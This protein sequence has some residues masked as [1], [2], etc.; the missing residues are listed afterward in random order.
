MGNSGTNW[1]TGGNWNPAAVPVSG[2]VL[3]F[4]P[5][6]TS[7]TLTY[8]NLTAANPS[9]TLLF[10][11]TSPAYTIS[12][13]TF[14]I[15]GTLSNQSSNT[16]TINDTVNWGLASSAATPAVAGTGAIIFNGLVM[17]TVSSPTYIINNSLVA[18]N[19]GYEDNTTGGRTMI[20]SGTGNV[21][22]E[23]VT[24]QATNAGAFQLT[25]EGSGTMILNGSNSGAM[26]GISGQNIGIQIATGGTFVTGVAPYLGNSTLQ[27]QGN[28]TIGNGSGQG[29]LTIKGGNGVVTSGSTQGTLSLEDGTINTLTINSSAAAGS[30]VFTMAGGAGSPSI[31]NMDVGNAGADEIV[32][33]N[34][35]NMKASIGAGGVLVNLNGIGNL[36]AG[37]YKLISGSAGL[38]TI[39]LNSTT[40]N[41]SGFDSVSLT[42]TTGTLSVTLGGLVAAPTNAYWKGDDGADGSGTW[43]TFTGGTN[44]VTNWTSAI[45]GGTNTQQAPGSATN[46]YFIADTGSNMTNTYLGASTTINT[47]NFTGTDATVT[48]GSAVSISGSASGSGTNATLTINSGLTSGLGAGV[49]TISAPVALGGNQTWTLNGSV[50]SVTGTLSGAH[51]LTVAGTGGELI[52]GGANTFSGTL[53]IGNNAMVE[54]NSAGALG[55]NNAVAFSAASSGTLVLNGFGA[56][57]GNLSSGG[58]GGTPV[59][60]NNNVGSAATLTGSQTT[61]GTFAGVIQDGGGLPLSFTKTGAATLTLTGVNTYTGST[62]VNGGALYINGSLG[63]G[64]N[65]AVNS[66]GTLGGSAGTVSG[67]V[68]VN[69]GGTINPGTS[70][71]PT[72]LNLGNGLTL[73]SGGIAAFD[74]VD[75]GANDLLN[76]TGNVTFN[77]GAIIEVTGGMS[78]GHVYTLLT[79]SG[80]APSLSGVTQ[81]DL[82]G[83]SLAVNDPT[84]TLSVSGNSIILTVA[85]ASTAIPG[86]TITSPAAG[87][88]VMQNTANVTVNGNV[89]NTGVV[90]LNG[91]LSSSGGNFTVGN[92]G[93]TSGTFQT[94]TG[95]STAYTGT[96]ASV[97]NTLGLNTFNMTVTDGNALP[98]SATTTGTL[99]VLGN[100][101]VTASTGTFGPIHVGASGSASI[102]LSST[103]ADNLYTRVTVADGG[104]DSGTNGISVTGGA[105]STV[106][107]GTTSDIRS[108]TGSFGSIGVQSGTV[109]LTT[110]SETGLAG[111]SPIN[112]GAGYTAQIFSGKASWASTTGGSWATNG[113]WGDTQ[114]GDLNGAGAPGLAGTASIGDT[115]TFNDVSGQS[116]VST[117]SLNGNSPTLA[118]ITF[119]STNGYTI[120]PGSGGNITLQGASTPVLVST[121]TDTISAVM[122]GTGAGLNKS[123]PGTLILGAAN[124]YTGSTIIANGVVQT[125]TANALPAT[126]SLALGDNGNDSGQLVLGASQTFAGGLSTV[127]TGTS[128]AVVGG[129]T[130]NSL[131]TLNL[132]SVPGAVYTFAGNLGGGIANQNNLALTVS[133]SGVQVIS[134]SITYT[135]ATILSNGA[136]LQTSNMLPGSSSI[137]LNSGATGAAN[138]GVW[139][140]FLTGPTAYNFTLGTTSAGNVSSWTGGGFAAYGGVLTLTANSGGTLVWGSGGFAGT[141]GQSITFGSTTSNNQ[142]VLTNNIN[143]NTTDAFQGNITVNG[144]TAGS[145]TLLSGSILPGTGPSGL[146]KSGAGILYLSGANTYTGATQVANGL[147]IAQNNSLADGATPGAFGLDTS[148]ILIGDLA[149]NNGQSV[150]TGANL[151]VMINGAYTVARP[152]TIG[153]TGN[154]ANSITIGGTSNNTATFSGL[155]TAS[156]SFLVAQAATT[157]ANVLNITNGITGG[158]AGTDTVTFVNIGKVNVSGTISKGAATTLNIVQ[159]GPG[160][161]TLSGSNNYNGITLINQGDLNVTNSVGSATG[162]NT[163]TITPNA[164]NSAVLSGNGIISGA[165]IASATS[166]SVGT[167]HIGPGVNTSGNF[168][169]TGTLTLNGGLTLSNGTD[170]DFD[171]GSSSDLIA[172]TG[173][174]TLGSGITLNIA[175]SSGFS[176]GTPYT[177]IT[178]TGA[179][180]GAT[181]GWSVAGGPPATTD[182]FTSGGGV[183]TVTITPTT[184]AANAYWGGAYGGGG[185]GTWYTFTG[186][187]NYNT[188]WLT[189]QNGGTDPHQVPYPTT[190]VYFI[191]DTG[192]NTNTVLGANFTIN[193]LNF[194]GTDATVT[195]GPAVNILGSVTGSG[196][197]N[198]LTINAT[199]ANGNTPGSGITTGAGAGADTVTANIALGGNQTWTINNAPSTPFTVSGTVSGSQALTVTGTGEL[200]LGGNNTFTNGLTI[201][202][203]SI[204][205]LNS[206][207]ALNAAS[208]DSVTF[209]AGSSG[210]LNLSGNS[211]TVGSLATISGTAAVIQNASAN[212]VVLTGSQTASGT[213]AGVIQDGAGGGSLSFTMNGPAALTLT[214]SNAYTGSTTVNGGELLVN[215]SLGP[216]NVKVNSGGSL[217]GSGGTIN[218]AVTVHSG[219]SITA[220]VGTANSPATL[221]LA[222]GLT[223]SSGG[224]A[225]FNFFNNGSAHDE[226]AVTGNLTLASGA[227]LQVPSGVYISGTYALITYTG[228]NSN[229]TLAGV[230]EESLTGGGLGGN[231]SFQVNGNAIDLVIAPTPLAI[232]GITITSP[233]SGIRVMAGTSV[234]VTG[235]VANSGTQNALSGTLS[236]GGGSLTV[237]N[238]SPGVASVAAGG[239]A[240]YSGTIA[241]GSILGNQTFGVTV[242][243]GSATPTSQTASGTLDVVASRVVISNTAPAFGI[244]HEGAV[245]SGTITLSSTGADIQYTRV[246]VADS[247]APDANGISVTGGNPSET[248]NGTFSDSRVVSGTFTSNGNLNGTLTL[249]TGSEG[250]AGELPINVSV[251]Y[252][253]QVFSGHA[254][255]NGSGSSSWATNTSWG[256]SLNNTGVAGAPGLSG[257]LSLGDTATFGDYAGEIVGGTTTVNLS[258]VSP[259][260][261]GLTFSST[262]TSYAIATGTGAGVINLQNGAAINVSSGTANIAANLSGTG[263][264][265]VAPAA[266][267]D[268]IWSGSD[269]AFTGSANIASGT[270]T[271]VNPTWLGQ[272]AGTNVYNINSGAVLQ[273][274]INSGS[275]ITDPVV[276][277]G[278][279]EGS[280]TLQ[281]TGTGGFYISQGKLALQ[282]SAGAVIEVRNGAT[283]GSGGNGGGGLVTNNNQGTLQLDSGGSINVWNNGQFIVDA[284]T[285]SG[286]VNRIGFGNAGGGGITIGAANGSGIFNGIVTNSLGTLDV[287]KAG[288]GTELFTGANTYSGSTAV[289]GG[290]LR[291]TNSSGLGFTGLTFAAP[292][293]GGQ[294]TT[295]VSGSGA[296]DI[297]NGITLNN[298]ITLNN[299]S[300]IN[301]GTGTSVL[302]SGIAGVTFATDPNVAGPVVVTFGAGGA[303]ASGSYVSSAN[304]TQVYNAGG[305]SATANDYVQM[306]AA[307]SGYTPSAAPT[308]TIT[309]GG[310]ATGADA[311]VVSQLILSGT[312]NFIGGN[313]N[314]AINAQ[315]SGTGG[316]STTGAG[317]VTLTGSEIY[318]GTTIVAS[319]T[320]VDNGYIT[321]P[322]NVGVATLA[323]TGTVAGAVA[324]TASSAA[325]I[326]PGVNTNGNL[327]G[328]GTLTLSGGLTLGNGTNLDFDLGSSSDLIAV[329]GQL[330]LGSGIVLNINK[331]SG[332]SAGS[333]YNLITYSGALTGTTNGWTMAGG[334]TATTGSFT[335]AN[336]TISVSFVPINLPANAY[337]GGAQGSGGNGTWNT[338][339]SGTT[340]NWLTA[341]SSGSDTNQVPYSTTNVFFIANTGS[342]VNTYLGSNFTINSLNFTGTNGVVATGSVVSISGSIP[343]GGVNSSLTI[344]AT[345]INGNSAG[346]GLT[347]GPGAGAETINVNVVLGGNQT[348]TLGASP[349]APLTIGGTISGAHALTVG[350]GGQ[351]VLAGNN[352]F[353]GGLTINGSAS[354]V[355]NNAGALNS[356]TP[357]SVTFGPSSSGT[358]TLAG[359][360][361]AIGSLSSSASAV[362][363][364]IQ[365]ASGTPVLLT[366][367][368]GV[369]G[370]F[371]GAIQDGAGAG[372]TSM[373]MAG[374]ATLTL[375]GA[376]TYSGSTTVN[377]GDLQVNGSLASTAPVT[378]NSSGTLGG[379]GGTI[380]GSVT[381]NSGGTITGRAAAAPGT[382]NLANGLTL[383]TGGIAAFNIINGGANDQI[384]IT[385]GGLTLNGGA[386]LQVSAGL[387][388]GGTYALMT[389]TGPDPTLAGISEENLTGGALL[390][391]YSFVV[392]SG[393]VDLV[394]SPITQ[395]Y[396]N[397]SITSPAS[398]IRVMSNSSVPVSGTVTNSGITNT[399]SGT[400]SNGGG[401]IAV[402]GFSPGVATVPAQ[403][404]TSYTATIASTG[405]SLGSQ[406]FAVTVTDGN[407]YLT[408]ATATGT[409]DV[410][411]N[412]AVAVSGAPSFGAVHVGTVASGT[413]TLSSTGADTQYTRVTVA[414]SGTDAFGISISG[415]NPSGTFNGSYTDTRII[416]GT[417]TSLGIETGITLV[418]GSE[419]GLA[420]QSPINVPVGFTAQIFS[421]KAS[422]A[423]ASSGS[424][425]T[426]GNWGDTQAPTGTP[427]APG[428]SGALSIGDTAIFGDVPGEAATTTISLNGANP[429][430]AGLT[431][432]STSTTYTIATGTGNGVITL[433][434][435][436]TISVTAGTGNISAVLTG[437]GPLTVTVAPGSDLIVSGTNITHSGTTTVTSGTMTF[438]FPGILSNQSGSVYA[439]N[440]GATLELNAST[441]QNISITTG[442]LVFGGS[443]T[444]LKSGPGTLENHGN[445][446]NVVMA[447]TGGTIEISGGLFENGGPATSGTGVGNPT[448]GNGS[449]VWA[450]AASGTNK[451][452]LQI[453][454]G[455][456]FDVWSGNNVTVDELLGSGTLTRLGNGNGNNVINFG[457]NNG[458]GTFAGVITNGLGNLNIN[459]TGT[460]IEVLTGS[461]SFGGYAAISS[462][463][464]R[465]TNASGIGWGGLSFITEQ[466]QHTATASGSSTFDIYGGI[467]VNETLTLNNG[468]LINSAVGTTSVFDSGIAGIDFG[469]DNATAPGTTTPI[470][471]TFTGGS[472]TGASGTAGTVAGNT[473]PLSGGNAQNLYTQMLNAG[474]GY[475]PGAGI[476]TVVITQGSGTIGGTTSAVVSQLILTGANNFI[477][478]NGNLTINALISGGGG[479]ITI[480]T[481]TVTLT[482]ADTYT[483]TTGI[484]AGSTLQLGNGA[485]GYDGMIAGSPAL[486]D[487][488][489][490]I[491]DQFGS[492][493]YAGPISGTGS[494]TVE[495]SGTQTLAGANTYT[496]PTTIVAGSTLQLGNGTND[497]SIVSSTVGNNGALVFDPVNS[498]NLPGVITGSGGI[499]M[500]GV[501]N[502][503]LSG[504]NSYTGSTIINSGT[505]QLGS[506]TALGHTSGIMVS[507]SAALNVSNGVT[508]QTTN[509]SA[510]GQTL[511]LGNGTILVFGV[512]NPAADELVI[513]NGAALSLNGTTYIDLTLLSGTGGS[514]TIVTDASG[515][516]GTGSFALGPLP[517]L[518][519]G[520]ITQTG[521]SVSITFAGVSTVYWAGSGTLHPGFWSD[522]SNFTVD[523]AGSGTLTGSFGPTQD[524]VFSG[525]NAINQNSSAEDYNATSHSLTIKDP[526]GV[527]LGNFGST[528]TLSGFTGNTGINVTSAATG[529]N[530]IDTAVDLAGTPNITVNSTSGLLITGAISGTGGIIN[531]GA[532]MLTLTGVNNYTGGTQLISGT[533]NVSTDSNFGTS[534]SGNGVTFNPGA[535]NS[536]T[537]Q[538]AIGSGLTTAPNRT[539]TFVSGTGILDPGVA[540]NVMT[541]AGPIAG[542]AVMDVIDTGEVKL[543]GSVAF[544][545]T[546]LV[547]SGTLALTFPGTLAQTGTVTFDTA[548][549]ATLLLSAN[550]SQNISPAAGDS[551]M[552]SGNGTLL[553]AGANGTL[554]MHGHTGANGTVYAAVGNIYMDMTGGTME[555][556][557]TGG[558]FQNGGQERQSPRKAIRLM[559]QAPPHGAAP[560]A[561]GLHR[562]PTRPLCKSTTGRHSTHGMEIL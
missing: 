416:S 110:G 168:G 142:V 194:T 328:I 105:P 548:P 183:V 330:T 529:V 249:Q 415:G 23:S 217:G 157:G 106:F 219:G 360:S 102:T 239:V 254:T 348:W 319:G 414:D 491:Y 50:L 90:A 321:A 45:S 77:S 252:T 122:Q 108:V 351:M 308:V 56:I 103:G 44:N 326:S 296:L 206:A 538:A 229:P 502:Q 63:A 479:F 242:T 237:S 10:D 253:A 525:S 369:S 309:V 492:Y 444:L 449:I 203:S 259:S 130:T 20:Y 350:G 402:S 488:G 323:G 335:I 160:T 423:S 222:S 199:G 41:F 504:S 59:I 447:M 177:L 4:G 166:T 112:V 260:L 450:S 345:G 5:A 397:V 86:I 322:V 373:V 521:T 464:L 376:S 537:L 155:I 233:A 133:G 440:A 409:L 96:I 287:V 71:T 388:I 454:S 257:S 398:G 271:L 97:G 33:G 238:F 32:L 410:V 461:N 404:G 149:G 484:S 558:T 349:S 511:A 533:L 189:S 99:D 383:N 329:T 554:Q 336:G 530:E 356:T 294:H 317:T 83:N 145:S 442:S 8:D 49:D 471:V 156:Q 79:T 224:I 422:W 30:T 209:D 311:A 400:L 347:T 446:G 76:I 22:F 282:M 320:L 460:G 67:A 127:G 65:V 269:A 73:K 501:G 173:Q 278:T 406:T 265:T 272:G 227:I 180:T 343:G 542:T 517:A 395:A 27:I 506:A 413:I 544:N 266:G 338:F 93:P 549:A 310:S 384:N 38:A 487:N 437:T 128:N 508:P 258:G 204:V 377:G 26:N 36:A 430:L 344:N 379:A 186:G 68:T 370:T 448:N 518:A 198:T 120:A 55:G 205:V 161:T 411:A 545:G 560:W 6:G 262:N 175:Q 386:I 505:L 390:G 277:T 24:Q 562:S 197:N 200:I 466:G 172:V 523:A 121:G 264:L 285:G 522:Y 399:L 483:G 332:F 43:N 165:V 382:L 169:G 89:S 468:S 543:S 95:A 385:S 556:A 340:T 240:G 324:S 500:S 15:T 248:F 481:G 315:I 16:E 478:G 232:P 367:D 124:T 293:A 170:L 119:N 535:G 333:T 193:S 223:I 187:T 241:T 393:T 146:S 494:V 280:G 426:N 557:N 473:A 439:T 475:A 435:G 305:A 527:L 152:I 354:V 98:T 559:A 9:F 474:S 70:T 40:G 21:Q 54:L 299:G 245:V 325:H 47:L 465:I 221:T 392:N 292:A 451:A 496:G 427:G 268:L 140:P 526:A 438:A 371:K 270:L 455:A 489:T 228:V 129:T 202:G 536:V 499:T 143:L 381:V 361:V 14:T 362:A 123:G 82:N 85:A 132:G 424:W 490:L 286:I 261:A 274:N 92:F 532:D 374:P 215:G 304:F 353:T 35:S 452:S 421:G 246:T 126:T 57:I 441:P 91:T 297:S 84:Y 327:G 477:G 46:V 401:T 352:T 244:V 512:S 52:L 190:N 13:S 230:T 419:P 359:K 34:G 553:V 443:G 2:A 387:T 300:L 213:Y 201:S 425:A 191:A 153:A 436:V 552:F 131:L 247:P 303:A 495:G 407:A 11:N 19:G 546:A 29:F 94:G 231:Y 418:T 433:Q 218:G 159:N 226:I 355:L 104:L 164:N 151:G 368:Q 417:F 290:I 51:N 158:V 541:I 113:N 214:G 459:K 162:T 48:T 364:V 339:N 234:P 66:A 513:S 555:I 302:D 358:L 394:I 273:W 12:G 528:L 7:G 331:A 486:A 207:G 188:N 357:D 403:S 61:S 28:Y 141:G 405:S 115:A 251:N 195:T 301:G 342:N 58:G 210:A 138:G 75:G 42:T 519:T 539:F 212:P 298:A 235:T 125:V 456:S 208:P 60:Q 275:F 78:Q 334:P 524:L 150:P 316:F 111:Q 429:T 550:P 408:S 493:T 256:D 313:G 72:T 17:E 476:P 87:T 306:T 432:N 396:P 39:S 375:T 288:T 420:G 220:T 431:F 283:L 139:Q 514:F 480:G 174:L 281:I 135:G 192:S 81:E 136:V 179:L 88:R 453:D 284:L 498:G 507:G 510:S 515:F 289:T 250:L 428:L 503:E 114:A 64:S 182:T 295:T 243:D 176:L 482:M 31:L 255:W 314:L 107:N 148:A 312:N 366:V 117:V 485:S 147:L 53:G 516:Q 101:T 497:G 37:T 363:P 236:Y 540:G 346:S 380:N 167:A 144:T 279:I 74:I 462:G 137:S 263:S 211:V 470:T 365:N 267:S 62:I 181:T 551:I 171:L 561:T 389:Y 467:T 445:G 458:S 469:T 116:G 100:R 276:N 412:R 196:T 534:G 307:G 434:S 531:N 291:I 18:Y 457:I 318:T 69:N 25:Y 109:T 372:S 341:Q 463:T 472:G 337:W 378:V 118:G 391:N 3:E 178:Y 134:G 184:P 509:L 225:A 80:A 163:V 216:G 154:A 1:N 520:S 185:N 547:S